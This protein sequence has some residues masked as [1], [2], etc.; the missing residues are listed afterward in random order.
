[1]QNIDVDQAKEYLPELIEQATQG[2]EVVITKGG[3]PVARLIPIVKG[4]RRR[5]FGSARV[6]MKISGGFNDPLEDFQEY[7]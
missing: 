3:Q 4:K 1:M 7:G 6:L 5:Q 2:E